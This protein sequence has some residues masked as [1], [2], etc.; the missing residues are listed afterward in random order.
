MLTVLLGT[1]WV[2]NRDEI[3]RRIAQDVSLQKSNRI[4]IVPELISHDAE[5][6]LALTA[7]DEAS[8][9]AEVL[10]FTRLERRVAD[11]VGH[12][13][14]ECLDDGGRVV[15]M[16]SAARQLHSKLKAYASVE[17]RPEF[18]TGLVDAV[19]EFKQCCINADTLNHASAQTD[20]SLAQKLEELSL[21]LETY[22]GICENGKRDPRDQ[23]VWLL[24]ELE[25]STF[26]HE[27]VFYIDGFPDFTR[28]HMDILEHLISQ[29]LNVTISLNCDAVNS[30]A[31]A[32]QKAG[33]TA[34]ELLRCARRFGVETEIITVPAREDSL[35]EV[36]QKVFQGKI[37]RTVAKETLSV[38]RTQSVYQECVAAA[39]KIMERVRSGD[40]Y[41]DICVV[42]SDLPA[43]KSTIEMVFERC[44]IPVYLSGTENVLEKSVIAAVLAAM[45]TA[46]S[47]FERQDV[48]CYLKSV[49]SP[50]AL[51]V[52]DR[53]ENYA[54]LWNING[55]SWLND[56]TYHPAGLTAQ[57]TDSDKQLL[58]DLNSA[59]SAALKPL[60][61][62][63]NGFRNASNLGQQVRALYDFFEDIQ[64]RSRLDSLACELDVQGDNR[65]AQILNQLWE[66]LLSAMEQLYDVLGN[67]AWDTETFTRLFKLLL[68]QYNVG[69]IPTVLDSVIVGSV[70]A[71]RCQQSK[72]LIVLGAQEG[73]FPCYGSSMGVLTDQ[74]RTDLRKIGVPLT[75][76]SMNGL[77][78]SFSEIYGVICGASESVTVSC[79]GG[80][81]SFIFN[82]LSQLAGGE[83][84]LQLEA[85]SLAFADETE[86]SAYL[87]SV[88]AT[89]VADALNIKADYDE[90]YQKIR[91]SLGR[92]DPRNIRDLY[93]STLRLSASQVDKHAEC[94]MS[95]FLKY[96]L[97]LAERKTATVDPAEFGTYVHAVLED[98]V[99][100][101]KEQGGFQKVSLEDT[102]QLAKNY[103]DE[104]AKERFSQIDSERLQY[105]FE[106]N[107][108][109][110]DLIVC[111]LWNE[112]HDSK[113]QPVD[114]EVGFGDAEK[115]PA[116]S[117]CGQAMCAVLRGFVDRVDLWQDQDSSYFRVVDYKTGRKDFDYC[118]IYNG[119]GLQMLLYLFALE[120]EG[121][122][123]LGKGA[124]P[125]GVQYFPARVPFVPA[126]SILSDE[127][128]AI[129][130]EK[131][132]KRKGL[133]LAEPTV[134]D[135]MESEL[136]PK[137][138]PYSMKKDGSIS[139][140]IADKE[141]FDL[142]KSYV[143]SLLGKIVDEIA[144][145][146]I[147]ANPYTRG[148][149]HNACS[150]CPYGAICHQETVE[151]RR[152][153]KTI[154][155]Q[156]FWE[157]V[158][159]EVSGRGGNI[160]SA[161]AASCF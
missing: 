161:T 52:C 35:S 17:T 125:A 146:N 2:A 28:Q 137:R 56:W 18:L 92:V 57:W 84:A 60:A 45:D 53:L 124:I 113:F 68:S 75:G 152:N 48:L 119:I 96:G 133:L 73:A 20:G 85:G 154:T 33:E 103:S 131:A 13:A 78:T 87:V 128:A 158:Q 71:M 36:R 6:R 127:E 63:R 8:R 7:G 95:Y 12:A 25:C 115:M 104:Y 3:F 80:Q 1:D 37:D 24:E 11:T 134:L 91:H 114:V 4:L 72:H 69:T 62:L 29:S 43:Y 66:I 79:P 155:A 51:D 157:D 42:C 122:E 156:R 149:S 89:S 101:I 40:R 111:E 34:A 49:I 54:Y 27:H 61:D 144:S 21:L 88:G 116:I 39:Q 82:R 77:Q 100:S 16:A 9:F 143:Y 138:M 70:S 81:E 112:L 46:L 159:K 139:G 47:G 135:A 83:T 123:I 129:A 10:S 67:T 31:L 150:F 110:L 23:M 106:R 32:F 94:R 93:G 86:A 44:H 41:R 99:R 65:N 26:G 118:D 15:A 126:D 76:G 136:A 19:D 147:E 117:I 58:N 121:E 148:S 55:N 38:Y 30:S 64:L 22:D 160:N 132:W 59:R 140:D 109:E 98:T 14:Q 102:L 50:L 151:G 107:R 74:E 142:L 108:K 130:R 120:Q 141:Q 153:Y 97:R 90:M 105:L 5:R 145:G